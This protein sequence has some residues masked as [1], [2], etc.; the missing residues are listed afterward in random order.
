MRTVRYNFLGLFQ[1]VALAALIAFGCSRD[2]EELQPATFPS[3]AEV[4]LDGFSGGLEYVA[5]GGSKVTALDIDYDQTYRGDASMR[6]SVPD[7]NDP[8]GAYAGAAILATGG[9][10]LSGYN[11]LTFWIKG[12][13]AAN[14]DVIGLGNDLGENKYVA[15]LPNVAVTTNWRKVIIP[16]PDPAKLTVEKGMF[17]FSEAPENGRGYTFWVDEVQFEKLGT[18]A[19]PEAAILEG[20][21]QET[22][23]E[24]GDNLRI[25]GLS[26][27]F[28][29][30]NGIDQRVDAAPA[31][32]A[33]RSSNQSVATVNASGIVTVIDSGAAVITAGL[34]ALEAAGSLTIRSSGEPLLPPTAAP[35]PQVPADSVISMFS[36]AY[37]NVVVDTWNPFWLYST[38]QVADVKIGDD[39]LKRYKQLNFVGI[40]TESEPIDASRMTHFHMDIW[41]PDP[42]DPPATFK[43]LLR[44]YGADGNFDGGDD[45]F[46]ELTITSPTLRTGEWVSLD[47]PLSS[48]AGLTNRSTIAQL[49][50]SGE[51][52]NVFVDNVY[53]Y[54]GDNQG[55]GDTEPTE[56][57]PTPPQAAADVISLFSDAYSDVN[58]DSWRTDWSAAAYEEVTVAGNPAKKYSGLDFVGIETTSNPVDASG[59]THFRMDVWSADFTSFGVKLVDF[60]ADGAFGGGD[61]VE[62]Q[63]DINMPAQGTWV[64]LDI[65][66]SDFTGLTTR[67][68]IAQYILVGQPTGATTVWVDNMYF[69]NEGGGVAPTEPTEAAPT[70][71]QAAGDVI[72][73][74]SDAYSDVNVDFWRTDWS[75]ATYEEVTVAGNAAKKYSGLDF[76]GI[77]TT[78]NP[79]D[80][81]GMTHFRMDVWSADFTSFGV[82]LVDFGADGAFGGG[83][84]VEHQ[85]DIDMPAQGEWVSLDIPLSDFTELTTR[86]NIAQYILVGRPAGAT[87]VWVDNM[88]FYKQ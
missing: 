10:D 63:V 55:S 19:H 2:L 17:F 27:T 47:I 48:F 18:I 70:P 44:D 65:P 12:S 61:D 43:V 66:L 20:Q 14:V 45:S 52:P 60:G 34:G 82:K 88:Y 56:A 58:V 50:L 23:A 26:A 57:A 74:F 7:A 73:L 83:D 67:S 59:M 76:V 16:I 62:H 15:S 8:E 71:P 39:D 32:F 51:I 81:S 72:S 28:N 11:A 29:M 77:E 54:I 38:T 4:F 37:D 21:D 69:Y 25:G 40:L 46:H 5:F 53:Y 31:Y 42:T 75:A 22:N 84:D 87:T 33:F 78:S 86:S 1:F 85:V 79:V 9:R 6:F 36:N 64:S 68:S 30:P 24:T 35:I 13:Q 80:A 41:T 49:V 3:D